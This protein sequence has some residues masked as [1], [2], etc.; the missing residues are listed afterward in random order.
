MS[1]DDRI[2]AASARPTTPGRPWRRRGAA[3]ADPAAGSRGRRAPRGGRR[4]GRGGS[5]R[6]RRAVGG[7]PLG[8]DAA[9]D[10]IGRPRRR[11]QVE[12]PG[13]PVGTR[14]PV[15]HRTARRGRPAAAPRSPGTGVRRPG[16]PAAARGPVP[17]GVGD[18]FEVPPSSAACPRTGEV[19]DKV[20]MAVDGRSGD[21]V[22]SVR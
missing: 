17:A 21:P 2:R 18:H 15:A 7:G 3:R 5:G 20:A 4:G 19:L 1:V 16:R 14:G 22:T 8:D 11:A 13:R 6:R 9:P 10:P 12:P